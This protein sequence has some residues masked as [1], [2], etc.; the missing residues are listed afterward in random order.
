MKRFLL[1]WAAA[2]AVL[3]I[4]AVAMA[5]GPLDAVPIGVADNHTLILTP[6][7]WTIITGLILPFVIGIITK[8]AASKQIKSVVGIVL[9]AVA[10]IVERATLTDGSA[11]FSSGLF[12]DVGLIYVPSLATYWGLWRSFDINKNLAPNVGIG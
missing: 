1:I 5:D 12:L 10:A 4:P 6:T 8:Y 2:M 11:V 7:N 9:A 3:W